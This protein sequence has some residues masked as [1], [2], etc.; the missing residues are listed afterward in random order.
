M[1]NKIEQFN[2]KRVLMLGRIALADDWRPFLMTGLS[3]L[4]AWL[5]SEATL[6]PE[7]QRKQSVRLYRMAALFFIAFY[8]F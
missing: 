5:Q 1:I 4:A 7:L 2:P 8:T 3:L 6:S